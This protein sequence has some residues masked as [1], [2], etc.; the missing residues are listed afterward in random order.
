MDDIMAELYA[1]KMRDIAAERPEIFDCDMCGE[2]IEYGEDYYEF[3]GCICCEK[4]V[5]DYISEYR[6]TADYSF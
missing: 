5:D 1:E 4:C 3:D 2:R 6:H